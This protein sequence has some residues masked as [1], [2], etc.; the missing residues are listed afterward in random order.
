[1]RSPF[2]FTIAIL[3][4]HFAAT[5]QPAHT[6]EKTNFVF[7]IADDC[8]F[9]DIGCYGGQAH[10]PNINRLATEGMR[11][12]RCFQAAPMCSPTRHNILT[13]LYPVKSG[14]YPNHTFAKAGTKSIAHYF[15]PLGY[16]VALS[17]KTHIGPRDVFPFEYSGKKN[18]DMAEVSKLFSECADSDTPF[19]LFACSNEPHTPWNKG[20]ASRYPAEKIKLPPYIADTPVVREAFG[21]YLAEITYFDD[22]VGQI[23]KMLDENKLSDDTLVMVVSEQGNSLP[24]A[25]W[26]CYSNGLQSAM[27]VRWPGRVKPGTTTDAIVEYVDITPTFVDVAGGKP[28]SVFDGQSFVDVL[29]GKSTRHKDLAFGIM[30][31]RGIINGTDSYPIRTVRNERYR[32]VWNLNSSAKFRNAC[33]KSAEFQS[34]VKA[35][36]SGDKSAQQIVE[37]YQS[38]PEFELFDCEADPLELT[39]L[40]GEKKH[41][42][43]MAELKTELDKWMK[44]QGD[45]G[46]QAERESLLRQGRYRGK[47]LEEAEAIWLGKKRSA[48]PGTKKKSGGQKKRRKSAA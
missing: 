41:S 4:L 48:S 18:P 45:T 30:T 21:R 36:Q 16:R 35:A 24:F 28:A 29:E 10:T 9:R 46:L 19:C 40:A 42:A 33:T 3:T 37:R 12:T 11:F 27:I 25:K 34:M 43:L 15:K 23:L 7:I 8:T 38:R 20:D 1:M 44:S 6:A 13:G 17:G 26:T 47:T 2:R 22:Q 32:L 39:N 5:F 14:A 31:T